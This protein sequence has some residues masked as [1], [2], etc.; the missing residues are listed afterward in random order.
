MVYAGGV[1]K[2]G[3][4]RSPSC[5]LS[6]A[7]PL[8]GKARPNR[9]SLELR[10]H[11]LV[12]VRSVV[13]PFDREAGVGLSAFAHRFPSF[14]GQRGRTP[15]PTDLSRLGIVQEG[16]GDPYTSIVQASKETCFLPMPFGLRSGGPHPVWLTVEARSP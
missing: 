4:V 2:R 10:S 1:L 7:S 8:G 9:V 6:K 15:Q 14:D 3:A 13:Q 11:A 5:G 16:W 12:T